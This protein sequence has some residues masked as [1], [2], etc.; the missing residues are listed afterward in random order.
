MTGPGRMISGST[1]RDLL[2]CERRADLDLNG[3]PGT[4]DPVSPFVQ[5]LWAEGVAHEGRILGALPGPVTD[6][7]GMDRDERERGTLR[8]IH[9][10]APTV[11]GAVL[12]HG[13]LV[14]MPDLLRL[15]PSGHLAGDVKSGAAMT[16]PNATYRREYLV[17]VA[18]YA[19]LLELTGLGRG[20]AAFVIDRSGAEVEYDLAAPLGRGGASGRELHLEL[21]DRAREVATGAGAT[22]PA[23]SANC[24]MCQWRTACRREL[25]EKDDVTLVAGLGRSLREPVETLAGTVAELA[26]VDAARAPRLKG[27]GP[28][29][30][31]RFVGRARLLADPMAG[32][33]VLAPLGLPRHAAEIDFDVEADPLRGIVYLHG[34]WHVDAEGG[35]RFFH[36]YAE[37]PDEAGERDA[38]ARA[39]E[40]FR[41]HRAGHWFHYS[42]YERTAYRD[43]QRRHPKVCSEDEIEAIFEAGRC[44]DLYATVTRATD[45]PLSS[46]GI[47]SIAKACGFEWEDADPGGANSIEWFDRWVTTR[48]PALRDRIVA[49]N[50]DDVKASARVREALRELEATGA[51]VGFRRQ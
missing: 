20:D 30:L 33:V 45:W 39:V 6:L 11:L 47:K 36:F 9:D 37:T 35:G 7:R 38:F 34:F 51:I 1:I 48:D 27:V 40:H 23:L 44:T 25:L 49:Y 32:P 16:G 8:A 5:M 43:L 42:A 24:G 17:Q 13:D 14:G 28:E 3:D 10:G 31:A 26:V 19:R 46:Y 4:R 29:R 15:T 12:R 21:L 22:R 2:L 18:H 41:E 50:R